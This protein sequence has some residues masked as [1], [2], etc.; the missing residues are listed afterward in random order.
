MW[1]HRGP[2]AA[3]ADPSLQPGRLDSQCGG[4]GGDST[5]TGGARLTSSWC[6]YSYRRRGSP[7]RE[8]MTGEDRTMARKPSAPSGQ[9]RCPDGA[10]HPSKPTGAAQARTSVDPGKASPPSGTTPPTDDVE[11]ITVANTITVNDATKHIR[12]AAFSG[13]PVRTVRD[14]RERSPHSV[15]SQRSS[16][17]VQ[18]PSLWPKRNPLSRS[19]GTAPRLGD[20]PGVVDGHFLDDPSRKLPTFLDRDASCTESIRESLNPMAHGMAWSRSA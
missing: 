19:V 16:R 5:T 18:P 7:M 10:R 6:R 11:Q 17:T 15:N 20:F 4:P 3:R 8:K 2:R 12:V 9:S 13:F 1:S 14:V